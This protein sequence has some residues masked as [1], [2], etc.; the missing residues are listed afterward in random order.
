LA[1]RAAASVEAARNIVAYDDTVVA[2]R[3]GFASA[4]DYYV[5]CS[6]GPLL[7]AIRTPALIVHSRDDPWIPSGAFEQAARFRN[8]HLRIVLTDSGG[9]VGFHGTGGTLPW[10]DRLIAGVFAES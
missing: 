5:R 1:P 6:S 4:A 8:P 2:P 7:G 9:H 3:Y 10:H